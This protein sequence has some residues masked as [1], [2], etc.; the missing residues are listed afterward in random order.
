[1]K[2]TRFAIVFIV[3]AEQQGGMKHKV[4]KLYALAHE[5]LR[6]EQTSFLET[7]GNSS[8][9]GRSRRAP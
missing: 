8:R 2:S 4:L 6:S 5:P 7:S 9:L 1:V 3:S